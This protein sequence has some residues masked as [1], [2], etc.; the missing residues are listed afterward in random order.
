[1]GWGDE[2]LGKKVTFWGGENPGVV[3]GV[4][5]DFNASSLRHAQEP[6]FLVKG[7][8][9]SGFLQIRLTGEDVQG[10]IA[11]VNEVWSRYDGSNPFEYFFLDQKFN[12]QYKADVTQNR[13]LAVLAYVSVFI[14]FLGI[15]GLAAFTAT[16]RTKEIG[17]RKVLGASFPDIILLLSKGTLMIVVISSIAVL[18]LSYWAVTGWLEG[19]AYTF[20][21]GVRLY[22]MITASSLTLVLLTIIIQSTN[23]A[24]RNPSETLKHE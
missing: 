18:P 9:R 17:V 10:T 19:F 21:P 3:I 22:A 7:H 6:M 15:V 20:E 1:M 4:V 14:S 11:L 12:E 16:Q 8:W 23:A 5:K 13:L 2:P 24:L